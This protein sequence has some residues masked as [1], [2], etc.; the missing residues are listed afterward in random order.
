MLK[1]EMCYF[2]AKVCSKSLLFLSKYVLDKKLEA[3]FG[4]SACSQETIHWWCGQNN[5]AKTWPNVRDF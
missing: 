1:F 4:G 3:V 5:L 2:F